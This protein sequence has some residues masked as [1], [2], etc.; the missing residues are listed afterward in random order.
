MA[1]L[2]S[3]EAEDGVG[4]VRPG[5]T[6]SLREALEEANQNGGTVS[7]PAGEYPLAEPLIIRSGVSLHLAGGATIRRDAPIDTMLLN[8]EPGEDVGE[9]NGES[10]ITVTGGVW[11]GNADEYPGDWVTPLAFGHGQRITIRDVEIRDIAQW[12]MTE[13]NAV[14]TALYENCYFHTHTV[15]QGRWFSEMLEIDRSGD[16]AFPWFGANDGTHSRNI[17]VRNCLFEDGE[18]VGIGSHSTSRGRQYRQLTIENCRFENL[19]GPAVRGENWAGATIADC[20]WRECERALSWV[21][22]EPR[23]EFIINAGSIEECGNPNASPVLSFEAGI[24]D[25]ADGR[26][27]DLSASGIEGLLLKINGGEDIQ[28]TGMAGQELS[29]DALELTGPANGLTIRDWEISGENG[30]LLIGD[31]GQPVEDVSIRENRLNDVYIGEETDGVSIH[32]NLLR[33]SIV[34]ESAGSVEQSDNR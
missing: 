9:Y 10:D 28:I 25:I 22:P 7:V 26:I 17:T 14:D 3:E 27:R 30:R 32:H 21:G 12:H 6:D 4:T 18:G 13:V 16:S 5:E 23:R 31:A 11:D 33:G 8:G 24:G 15:T 2:G 19:Q 1:D 29:A 34:N 20:H